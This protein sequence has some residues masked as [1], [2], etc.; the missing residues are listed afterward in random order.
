MLPRIL[1]LLDGTH[2]AE[3]AIPFAV[4]LARAS[5]GSLML[6]RMLPLPLLNGKQLPCQLQREFEATRQQAAQY[7]KA[8]ARAPLLKDLDISTEVILGDSMYTLLVFASAQQA[9]LLVA[10]AS[11]W[12]TRGAMWGRNHLAPLLF[13]SSFP[14]LLVPGEDQPEQHIFHEQ[15]SSER[16]VVLLSW[17][18]V[19]S[20]EAVLPAA[21]FA[22]RLLAPLFPSVH[23][24]RTMTLPE[25]MNARSHRRLLRE[26]VAQTCTLANHL[27]RT[28]VAASLPCTLTWSLVHGLRETESLIQV[29]THGHILDGQQVVDPCA[30]ITVITRRQNRLDR[31]VKG[32]SPAQ[33]VRNI[34]VPVL[35][36]RPL[37]QEPS[38]SQLA[39]EGE[40]P[41]W[42][43]AMRRPAPVQ[44]PLGSAESELQLTSTP[45]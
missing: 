21:T 14:L 43:G 4:S 1:V 38:R 22:V 6:L 37:E 26:V 18:E 15:A 31:L 36:V 9:T 41:L 3:Q 17:E 23:L 39:E 7:V 33:V 40:I 27:E 11:P 10:S 24:L 29:A 16:P 45:G 42:S 19:L 5:R 44:F 30:V 35:F 32:N 28:L 13:Q 34:H 2:Q 8:L 20:P 25:T 12:R